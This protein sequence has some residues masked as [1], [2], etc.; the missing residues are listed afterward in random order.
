MTN[1]SDTSARLFRVFHPYAVKKIKE[2][3]E[4]RFVHYTTAEAA[5]SILTNREVWMRKSM[6]MNDFAEIEHGIRC[7]R[8]ALESPVGRRF[9]ALLDGLHPGVSDEIEESFRRSLP[10]FRTDTYLTSISE[11]LDSE[12]RIGRLSMWRAYGVNCGVALVLNNKPF[13]ATSDALRAYTSPVAYFDVPLFIDGLREINAQVER[14]IVLLKS[15]SKE[16]LFRVVMGMWRFAIQS[17]KHRGFCEEREWRV[18]YLPDA[19]PSQHL[20]YEHR[21][22]GGVPQ[23][24]YKIPLRDIPEE[25]FRGAEIPELLERVIIG[26]TQYPMAILETIVKLL[27]DAGVPDA[28]ERVVI[29]DIPIRR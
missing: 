20:K 27:G 8:A 22:I 9:R 1:A 13:L 12:D 18:I 15:I 16:V 26:P 28:A 29:S 4:R 10:A 5:F 6:V 23:P 2:A 24:I 3:E 19:E 21:I 14:E 11:H 25:S 17:T 7:R